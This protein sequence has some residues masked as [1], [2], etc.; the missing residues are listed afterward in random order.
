MTLSSLTRQYL[1]AIE[2]EMQRVIDLVRQPALGSPTGETANLWEFLH[3]MLVYHL[4]WDETDPE[5]GGKRIRPVLLLLVIAAAGGDW[6]K[7]LPAAAAVELV[8]NFSLIHDDIEDNSPL[9]RGRPTVWKN[10]GVPQAINTGDVMFTLSHLALLRLE[11]SVDAATALESSRVMHTTC[12]ALT[13]GQFLDISYEE[14]RSL[15]MEAYWP[16]VRGKTGSLLAACTEL[17]ALVAGTSSQTRSAYRRF[18]MDLGLAF[19]IQDD[20][21]GIWGDAA[22]TGKSS[23]SDLLAGKKSL[24]VLYGISQNG[25]FA[26]RWMEGPIREDE[27]AHWAKV[28]KQEGGYDYALQA[29]E[30]LTGSSLQALREANPSGEAGETLQSLAISLL[31][32]QV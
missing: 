9:R 24:P 2:D 20:L 4:G 23:N 28:L 26:K 13:Q 30:K 27:V 14:S 25:E 10:W 19:Q 7:G 21:L 18:G 16:M 11:N 6:H 31:S 3:H 29:A 15:P 22:I 8:H 1:P 32:R 5:A 17:G 12:L